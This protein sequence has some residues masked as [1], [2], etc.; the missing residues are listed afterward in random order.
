[1]GA[2]IPRAP[3]RFQSPDARAPA[4]YLSDRLAGARL[5]Q[6]ILR[7][8]PPEFYIFSTRSRHISSGS[9][10]VHVPHATLDA[11]LRG[12]VGERPDALSMAGLDRC[13]DPCAGVAHG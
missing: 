2:L 13:P 4:V 7:G 12:V 10:R 3:L 1:M 5:R 11:I 9:R 8:R 6:E